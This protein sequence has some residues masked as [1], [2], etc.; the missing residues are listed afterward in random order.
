MHSAKSS[1]LKGEGWGIEFNNEL[2]F[3]FI[4]M[5]VNESY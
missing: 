5:Y 1:D 4:I 2:K 3:S